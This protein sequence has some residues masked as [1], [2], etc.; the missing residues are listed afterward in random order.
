MGEG[1]EEEMCKRGRGEVRERSYVGEGGEE[2]CKRRRG[3][4]RERSYVG[5]RRGRCVRG[6]RRRGGS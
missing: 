2:M 4:V 3:E 5:K 1:G 6:S